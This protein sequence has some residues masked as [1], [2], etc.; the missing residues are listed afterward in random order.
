LTRKV[1]AVV[2]CVLVIFGVWWLSGESW[3]DRLPS[4][5]QQWR[6][7]GSYFDRPPAWP[8]YTWERN[9]STVG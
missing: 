8:G 3:L 2:A 4:Q 6:T 7:V 9:G 1:I 5:A